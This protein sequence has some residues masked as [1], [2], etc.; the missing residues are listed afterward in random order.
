MQRNLG[1]PLVLSTWACVFGMWCGSFVLC[2]SASAYTKDSPKVRDMV[3]RAMNYL[4]KAN[5]GEPGGKALVALAH[6]KAGKEPSHPQVQKGVQAAVGFL[7]T[8]RKQGNFGHHCYNGAI[9]CLFLCELDSQRYA[10]EI[11]IYRQMLLGR[12][13]ASGMWTYSNHGHTDTSQTQYGVLCL[14]T[15][16]NK[17]FPVPAASLDRAINWMLRTQSN[18]GGFCYKPSDPGPGNFNLRGQQE[19]SL[20]MSAAALGSIYIA[21]DMF[22]MGA[23]NQKNEPKKDGKKKVSALKK[24][25]TK[26]DKAKKKAPRLNPLSINEAVMQRSMKLGDV[27]FAKNFKPNASQWMFYY[28]YGLERC[29][30]FRELYLGINDPE[31]D[32]YNQGVDALAKIQDGSGMW[33]KAGRGETETAFAVLFLTRSTKSGI[34]KVIDGEGFLIGGKGLP[35]NAAGAKIN[36]KGQVVTPQ[37]VKSM[38]ELLAMMEDA[39]GADFDPSSLPDGVLPL[40]EDMRKRNSQLE[41]LKELVSVENWQVRLAA[42]NNLARVRDLNNV[43]I[44]LYSLEDPDPRVALAARDGLRF[45]SRK[46]YGFRMPSNAN[47]QQKELARKRWT[48]WYR[49]VRPYAEIL[50]Q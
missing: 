19:V 12:Q 34:K 26:E 43:P 5:P 17:G 22:G 44:L 13:E 1:R 20:S 31:P 6:L 15:L 3:N 45:I 32:W 28:L 4:G 42:V 7:D 48:E 24:V 16:H 27:W 41:R 33:Q 25:E 11:N 8:C 39:G 14:W 50:N 9:C 2:G 40:E 49:S 35:K 18:N 29:M 38:D 21:A 36:D 37:S 10:R 46:F 30:S 47:P 23:R